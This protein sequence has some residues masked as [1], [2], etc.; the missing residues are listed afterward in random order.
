MKT[1]KQEVGRQQRKIDS[2]SGLLKDLK[3][4][5]L[6]DQNTTAK[7]NDHF[8]GIALDMIKN[9]IYNQDRDPRGR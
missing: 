1:L 9:Q 2:L 8:S 4:R 3:E 7:F 6:I 5:T